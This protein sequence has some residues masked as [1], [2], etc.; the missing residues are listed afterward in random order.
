MVYRLEIK[1]HSI[2]IRRFN[3]LK[4]ITVDSVFSVEEILTRSPVNA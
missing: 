4:E 2:E 3:L 1:L